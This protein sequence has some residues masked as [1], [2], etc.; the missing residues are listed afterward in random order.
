MT[1]KSSERQYGKNSYYRNAKFFCPVPKDLIIIKIAHK[2]LFI[3]IK[4]NFKEQSKLPIAH[5]LSLIGRTR[6][7]SGTKIS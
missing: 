2:L 7:A 3:I 1:D 6:T 5:Y 4:N